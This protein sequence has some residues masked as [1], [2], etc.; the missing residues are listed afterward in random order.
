[1]FTFGI[2]VIILTSTG[3][4]RM[5]LMDET[6][7]KYRD[8]DHFDPLRWGG[9]EEGDPNHEESTDCSQIDK[10]AIKKVKQIT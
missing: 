8:M 6:L 2:R 1:M 4:H 5:D 9:V 7:I 3:L 10:L